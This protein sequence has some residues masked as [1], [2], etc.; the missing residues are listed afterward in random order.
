S[1]LRYFYKQLLLCCSQ[2]PAAF[3]QGIFCP[4]EGGELLRL[5]PR[6]YLH[7]YLSQ[8][9][10]GAM[11][12]LHT[13]LLKSNPS[14]DLH[15]SI[16]GRLKPVSHCSPTMLST[17]VYCASGS[18]KL[19]RWTVLGV[20]GALLSHFLHPVY[21]TSIVLADSYHNH[22][23][24]YWVLN[25]HLH[26]GPEEGFP[27]PYGHKKIYLFEGP[28]VTPFN[29]PTEC[30]ALSLNWCAGDEML[31]CVNGA[32]GKAERDIANPGGGSR[33]S[34][35]CKAAMLKSF[36][37]VA[38]EMKREDLTLLLPYHEAK[39]QATTYQRAKL[40]LYTHLSVRNLSKWPQKQLVDS[41]CR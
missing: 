5:K 35:L 31:E 10:H 28:P 21:I 12:K 6:C 41:F 3:E 18:D 39:V 37:K 4:V 15:V 27:E 7:L 19:T 24:L 9:P 17:H 33:P 16:K 38:Q 11:K 13:P 22:D 32:V 26:L 20:Q 23:I 34:R 36:R 30:G 29:S 14:V 1:V 8:M 2:D 40:Q 25:E